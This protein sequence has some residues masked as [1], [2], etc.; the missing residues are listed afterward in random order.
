MATGRAYVA[1]LAE[2]ARLRDP[3]ERRRVWRQAMASLAAA[4]ADRRDAPL[5]GIEPAALVAGVRVA[6]DD[7]L[8]DDMGFLAP[9]ATATATFALANALPPGP[10]RRELG[11]RVLE[12]LDTGDAETFVALAT[13]LARAARRPLSGELTRV[14]V[15]AALSAPLTA[16]TAADALALALVAS[17]DLQRAWVEEP[18]IGSLP[19]RRLAARVLER[20]AREAARRAR[21]GDDGALAILARPAIRDVA[22]RLLDDRESLVWRH[23]AV[24]RG[25]LAG[26]DDAL[27]R[28]IERE[29]RVDA[30]P[31]VWRRGATSLAARLEVDAE[32]RDQC[33][34]LVAG[35]L[36][37]RDPGVARGVIAGLAGVFAIDP[38]LAD[39]LAAR[40]VARSGLDA[41]E[42]LVELRHDVGAV[43]GRAVAE[44]SAWLA[45]ARDA[46]PRRAA[47][48]G[49]D[50][51]D[52]QLALI[53]S[54]GAELDAGA[55]GAGGSLATC[56]AEARDAVRAGRV[57]DAMNV[58]LGAVEAAA[59]LVEFL[60]RAD[61]T[62]R[63]ERRHELRSLR[64]LDRDL[65]SDGTVGALLASGADGRRGAAQLGELQARL[66]TALLGREGAPEV[67]DPPHRTLRLARLRV[68]VRSIDSDSAPD[69]V[70]GVRDR[71]VAVIRTLLPRARTDA[72]TVRR[73]VWAAITRAFEAMIRDDQLELSDLIAGWTT[74][75]DPDED[76]AIAREAS[77]VPEVTGVLDAYA[78]LVS[79]TV[80]AA[81]PD[82]RA[83]SLAAVD[84]MSPLR[85]ALDAVSGPRT[86]ILRTNL[87]RLARALGSLVRARSQR[88]APLAAF[89]ELA[90]SAAVL[91]DLV[92]GA[93][94][95]LGLVVGTP[96]SPGALRAL[97]V[98][99]ERQRNGAPADLAADATG[100][101][102]AALDDQIPA[103]G[104]LIAIAL[105]RLAQLPLDATA[106]PPGRGSDTGA[107][108]AADVEGVLPRWL[109]ASRTIG[110]FYVMRPLGR[111]A[112][113]SVFIAYR[114][115]ERH[116]SSPELV[117][118]KVPDY[119]G[120]AARNL[121]AAEF[122]A[123]F[124]EEAGA[125]LALPTHA[126]LAQFV[127]FDAGARPKPCLVMEYV[128]GQTLEHFLD[129][130]SLNTGDAM[131]LADGIAA[132]LEAMHR[133]R[134][135]HL[136][137]KPANVILR[138]QT[139]GN[140]P[141]LVDFGLAGRRLR[142][143]CGSPHYGAPEVWTNRPTAPEP[144]AA[145]VYALACVLF[146]MLTGKVLIDGDSVREIVAKHLSGAARA[147]V[148]NSLGRDRRTTSI[149]EV[150]SAALDIRADR[151]PPIARVRAGVAA[152]AP[153]LATVP[154]PLRVVE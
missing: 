39:G 30:D 7:G 16:G 79:A 83:A 42:A 24:A 106:T 126:N 94:R 69:D 28:E 131:R 52:G 96:L 130:A 129:I 108:A 87:A 40:A 124:R 115:E 35:E 88:A 125:L 18:A 37:A 75:M 55:A 59:E 93:R 19:S 148:R 31:G 92:I 81:D 144:Y 56:A 105:A 43:G 150:L 4:V 110:G 77:M 23:A 26:T 45:R 114:A 12:R 5:E 53:A 146:E 86:E 32:T 21:G 44:A 138:G 151:R 14:R 101:A 11:R 78:S 10:E 63:I 135:A 134:V 123:L 103:V 66:E 120:G 2:L 34:A 48:G 132:G 67:G 127:T 70:A 139:P 154:W 22:R 57:G 90:A 97:A 107:N 73:G 140:V 76:F 137:L 91:A 147:R 38:E 149:A 47:T 60:E 17:P 142:P 121:S 50:A 111:G 61:A 68:L 36:P 49:E 25:L 153:E 118:L 113:G 133:A 119:D 152:I 13:A 112:G 143:G 128:P 99:L 85:A 15:A 122:E 33:A 71:R 117:A 58:A 6:L 141:V 41:I 29:V 9:A 84:A 8:I 64:E 46:R 100:A 80:R 95:R 20:A 3:D 27:D 74:A 54:L 145:D 51:D 109:P 116:S 62:D 82:D 1:A 89:D 98:T 104:R 72:S 65:L 136:D 102:I